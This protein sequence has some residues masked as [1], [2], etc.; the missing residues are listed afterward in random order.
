M[1]D[2]LIYGNGASLSD[3]A[4][5]EIMSPFAVAQLNCLVNCTDTES[6]CARAI[7]VAAEAFPRAP[8]NTSFR[9]ADEYS[10]P[11]ER[12]ASLYCTSALENVVDPDRMA[13]ETARILRKPASFL[14]PMDPDLRGDQTIGVKKFYRIVRSP[15]ETIH[16]YCLHTAFPRDTE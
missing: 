8:G 4:E 10:M 9:P 2:A 14:D 3:L 7:R 12:L 6:V 1:L 16:S 5:V 11:F 15:Q 13:A